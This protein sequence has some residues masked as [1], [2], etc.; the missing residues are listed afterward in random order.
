MTPKFILPT[1]STARPAD[2]PVRISTSPSNAPFSLSVSKHELQR[3]PVKPGPPEPFHF[4]L[5]TPPLTAP[6]LE[7][8]MT[9]HPLIPE[10][11]GSTFERMQ[12]A[13]TSPQCHCH[14]PRRAALGCLNSPLNVSLSYP[15][16]YGPFQHSSQRRPVQVRART[17]K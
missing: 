5:K 4:Q 8:T 2:S 17:S 12:N 11:S 1:Q 14:H 9:S 16:A 3:F 15:I 7:S 10:A 13:A 6:C